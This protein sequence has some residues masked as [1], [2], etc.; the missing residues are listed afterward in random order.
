MISMVIIE[1]QTESGAW[2]KFCDG[3]SHPSNIKRM[4]DSA[5]NS[6]ASV[7]KARAIDSVTK[8][9]VDMAIKA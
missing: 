2:L 5:L 8:Q 1:I 6:Q 4:L 3:G 9:L 7:K